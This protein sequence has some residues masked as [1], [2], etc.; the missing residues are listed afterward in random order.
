VHSIVFE[1]EWLSVLFYVNAVSGYIPHF[2]IFKG[3]QM[4]KNYI[5]RCKLG[6]TMVI[7]SKAWMRDFSFLTSIEHFMKILESTEKFLQQMDTY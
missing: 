1:H 6:V 4:K 5:A 7:Q 2:Y 3:K